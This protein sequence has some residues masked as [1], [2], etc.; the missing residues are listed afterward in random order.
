MPLTHIA[1]EAKQLKGST[2]SPRYKKVESG[3][4]GPGIILGMSR[5]Y[6]RVS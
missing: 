2:A 5:K 3:G 1:D 4:S 6:G